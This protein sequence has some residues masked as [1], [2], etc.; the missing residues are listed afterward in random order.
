MKYGKI[1]NPEP[2][3]KSIKTTRFSVIYDRIAGFDSWNVFVCIFEGFKQ[4][5]IC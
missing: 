4:I 2:T 1:P 5:Q 3:I